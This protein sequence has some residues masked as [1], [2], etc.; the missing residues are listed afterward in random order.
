M[1]LAQ[2]NF[3]KLTT[4]LWTLPNIFIG[5]IH[6]AK[7]MAGDY[8][9]MNVKNRMSELDNKS[10]DSNNK[11][12]LILDCIPIKAS[13]YFQ[14]AFFH[15]FKWNILHVGVRRASWLR[16]RSSEVI[17][18]FLQ[19]ENKIAFELWPLNPKKKKHKACLTA[20]KKPHANHIYIKAIKYV[21]QCWLWNYLQASKV[22]Q[23]SKTTFF[24]TLITK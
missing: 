18:H 8:Y 7:H 13:D 4:I 9:N 1:I 10:Y 21:Q 23:W 19:F 14:N 24:P 2:M 5:I 16:S 11:W 6:F 15:L 22:L 12:S 20:Y 17:H 3:Q